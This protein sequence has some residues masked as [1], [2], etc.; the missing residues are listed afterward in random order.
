M[1]K[2]QIYNQIA[3]DTTTCNLTTMV[4][5]VPVDTDDIRVSG[6]SPSVV[7]SSY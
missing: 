1:T 7:F 4:T 2:L 3:V 6:S 5:N